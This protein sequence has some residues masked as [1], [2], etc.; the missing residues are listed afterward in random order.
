L[1]LPADLGAYFFS[2]SL[3]EVS[4]GHFA[5]CHALW[6]TLPPAGQRNFLE[7][8][9]S[10]LHGFCEAAGVAV[11]PLAGQPAP[12]KVLYEAV[13]S[14]AAAPPVLGSNTPAEAWQAV[15][16]KRASPNDS[17]AM[18][19]AMVVVRAGLPPP[20]EFWDAFRAARASQLDGGEAFVRRVCAGLRAASSECG[21]LV[22]GAPQTSAAAVLVQNA[23]AVLQQMGV[24]WG[25]PRRLACCAAEAGV[26]LAIFDASAATDV[27]ACAFPGMQY[28]LPVPVSA[29]FE[30]WFI[31]FLCSCVATVLI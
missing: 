7:F 24:A 4:R 15:A 26:A 2:Q 9:P 6:Q 8:S 3:L 13:T 22:D 31:F 5:H 23:G 25:D 14:R 21:W 19:I 27:A 20:P 10:E 12:L 16:L 29:H 17:W 30:V 1:F 28:L 18:E 11:P